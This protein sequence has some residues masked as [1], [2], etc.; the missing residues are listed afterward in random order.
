MGLLDTQSGQPDV[1]R[2]VGVAASVCGIWNTRCGSGWGFQLKAHVP[3]IRVV[4]NLGGELLRTNKYFPTEP[5]P[6]KRAAAFLVFGRLYPF[7]STNNGEG[8]GF[9]ETERHNWNTRFLVLSIG[10]VLRQTHLML[11]GQPHH[12]MQGWKGFPSLHYLL[13]FLV[14]LRWLDDFQRFEKCF[15]GDW[16]LIS[17][18]RLARMVMSTA[19]I[20]EAC[21]YDSKSPFPNSCLKNL[22]T[23][24]LID[25]R[26][27][28]EL[29]KF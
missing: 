25:L 10:P 13:E 21:Y 9:S 18:Q 6:F 12:I 8:T 3:D 14:W 24:Q 22:S 2:A 26:Y 4:C 17:S 19:L 28:Y 5:G 16:P 27:D 23:E 20:L 29:G 15:P 1:D 7:Y 11:D